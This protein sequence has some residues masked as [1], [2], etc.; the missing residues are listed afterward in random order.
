MIA[1]RKTVPRPD[2]R[3][4]MQTPAAGRLDTFG[5][6][7]VRFLAD[8]FPPLV[9][10]DSGR[11]AGVIVEDPFAATC[12][13]I[14]DVSG[15]MDTPD[16]PPSRLAGAK[17][18]ARA[19]VR[20]LRAR[21]PAALLAIVVYD[22]NARVICSLTRASNQS[23]IEQQID[24]MRTGGYTSITAGL[25]QALPLLAPSTGEKQV[26]LLTDGHHNHGPSPIEAGEAIRRLATLECVGIGGSPEEVD[27]ELL[28]SIASSRPDGSKRY[29]WIG[30]PEGLVQHFEDLANG[31]TRQP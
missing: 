29:R 1:N 15:S 24:S 6:S 31:I 19:Y 20:R 23:V 11:M 14:L 2:G 13:L 9:E 17:D 28:R 8:I 5:G 7:V 22:D 21:N 25:E 3:H 18:A 30:N 26:I 12:V 4:I 16:W 10:I 27:E